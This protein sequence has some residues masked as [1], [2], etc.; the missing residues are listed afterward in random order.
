MAEGT[1]QDA[2]GESEGKGGV[3]GRKSNYTQEPQRLFTTGLQG[4]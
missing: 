4:N 2:S 3:E 1:G